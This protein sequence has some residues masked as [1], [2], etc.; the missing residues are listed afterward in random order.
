M[1]VMALTRWLLCCAELGWLQ[2]VYDTDKCLEW[3]AHGEHMQAEVQEAGLT[4]ED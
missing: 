4:P 3:M 2:A 1:V